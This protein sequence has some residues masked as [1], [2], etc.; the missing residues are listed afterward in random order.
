MCELSIFAAICCCTSAP[1]LWRQLPWAMQSADS[2]VLWQVPAQ[3]LQRQRTRQRVRL[4]ATALTT[5]SMLLRR[6]H[7]GAPLPPPRCIVSVSG[8]LDTQRGMAM[9]TCTLRQQ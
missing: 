6:A 9:H 7:Q 8:P 4:P 2:N 5:W 3:P 1:L